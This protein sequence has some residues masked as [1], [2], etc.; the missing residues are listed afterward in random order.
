MKRLK[1]EKL[2]R[3]ELSVT[4]IALLSIVFGLC[5]IFGAACKQDNST[6]VPPSS[7]TPPPAAQN[8]AEDMKAVSE[9]MNKDKPAATGQGALPSGHPPISGSA[10]PAEP[11]LPAGHPPIAQ[12]SNA[13]PTPAAGPDAITYTAPT[14]WKSQQP[15]SQMR[16]AQ[17]LIPHAEGDTE[18]G[19]MVVFYFGQGQGGGVESNIER[20]KGMFST[21]DGKPLEDSA[22][23]RETREV[24]GLKVTTLDLTGRY[25]DAMGGRTSAAPQDWRMLSAIAETPQGL[26]FFKGV[27]PVATMKAHEQSFQSLIGSLKVK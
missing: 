5:I 19:Q 27:G 25:T 23:K 14:A 24:N 11:P 22:I 16:K 20:W 13:M 18:D 3:K 21:A 17:F 4:R 15:T 2:I 9:F 8:N 12:G 7:S 6:P 26:W 1:H 10:A